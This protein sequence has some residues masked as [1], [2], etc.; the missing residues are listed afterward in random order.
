[1]NR[2][3][4]NGVGGM[5]GKAFYEEFQHDYEILATDKNV[6]EP[7]LR[8]LDFRDKISYERLA[9]EFQPDYVF[10]IGAHTDLEY[11]EHHKDDCYLT[12]TISV[13]HA[14][15]IANHLSVPLVFIS[16]AGIF[17]G[18]KDLYDDRDTPNP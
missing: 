4:M 15:E 12:N 3:M 14:I 1:M 7:W 16:T 6:N 9:F 13:E 11:C 18:G 2:I 8:Y 17:D 5:L 10:H